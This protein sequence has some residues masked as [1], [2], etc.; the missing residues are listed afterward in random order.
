MARRAGGK[1]WGA[2]EA[3]SHFS[4]VLD[5]ALNV[6]P[7]RITRHGRQIAVL[8]SHEEFEQRMGRRGSAASTEDKPETLGD[9][10]RRS[11]LWR[12]GLD[13]SR[14]KAVLRDPFGPDARGMPPKRRR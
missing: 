5:L 13:L 7:Q 3:K 11:P 9:F 14:P 8:V 10:F 6:G 4:E 1:S 2:A 12:S